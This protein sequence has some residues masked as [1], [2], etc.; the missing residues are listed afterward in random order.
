M[1]CHPNLIDFHIFKMVIASPTS[2]VLISILGY[3]PKDKA[4]WMEAGLP[5]GN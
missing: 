3:P 2:Y 5:F 1:G 4:K